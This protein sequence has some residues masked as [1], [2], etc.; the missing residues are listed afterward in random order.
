MFR[1]LSC[2]TTEHDYR[3][4][5]LAVVICA[6]ASLTAFHLFERS[7]RTDGIQCLGW[8]F[9]TG[10]ATG[11]GIWATHFVAMLAF[12]PGLPVSYD[13]VLTGISLVIAV[14]VTTLGFAVG[15]ISSTFTWRALGGAIVGAGIASMHYTGMK[16]FLISGR[17]EWDTSLVVSSVVIGVLF[18]ALSLVASDRLTGKWKVPVC[19]A[20]L[21]I[22]ICGLHFTAMG[23]A[24]IVP[25][26]TVW[27]V[28]AVLD[29]TIMAL[30]VTGTSL[31]VIFAGVTAV[32]IDTESTREA[33]TRAQELV[34][35]TIEG[36][37]VARD[38]VVQNIN[39][40]VSELTGYAADDLL[41]KRIWPDLFKGTAPQVGSGLEN[42]ETSLKTRDGKEVPVEIV[43]RPYN[44][45]RQANEVYAI[46][47]LR[48]RIKAEE[49][50]SYLAHNDVLTGL[51]NR[52]S[53]NRELN[54]VLRNAEPT[55][56]PFAVMCLDLDRFKDVN[57]VMGHD[58]GDSVLE[59]AARR[60]VRAIGDKGFLARVGGDEFIVVQNRHR[61]PEGIEMLATALQEAFRESFEVEFQV[62]QLGISAGIALYPQNGTN[63][64]EL[65]SN[66]DT[67]LYRAKTNGRGRYCF[68]E[69][70]MDERQR[71][72]RKLAQALH[73]ALA[74]DQ[75][76]LN[77]QPQVQ[78]ST[79]QIIGF[80][81][82][83]RWRHPEH[84]IVS[85]SDFIP[86][87]EETGLIV[88]IGEWAL[89]TACA[90]AAMWTH[91]C[92]VAV[93]LSPR[94][95]QQKE[96][97][98]MVL[99]I[100]E[101]TRLD[102]SRLELEITETT[103]FQDHQNALK[104]L[105]K[106]KAL[107]V[108]I[109]MDDFGTGYSSLSTLQS[110]P[111]DKIKIDRSFVD[112]VETAKEAAAI[113]KSVLGLGK[114]LN[115]PVL[116]EGVER[117]GQLEFLAREQCE[118]VQGFY[119]GRPESS[120]HVREILKSGSLLHHCLDRLKASHARENGEEMPAA[121]AKSV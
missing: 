58:A 39:R 64:H 118:A 102:P 85:P 57:D 91:K 33:V 121:L 3:L 15:S 28:P 62:V 1:V 90:E 103:L 20:L 80:E 38:G 71:R 13:P 93:N 107:G 110:F 77:Y 21:T 56:E 94:Q 2:L 99:Q 70:E 45:D 47:D 68:F 4:V 81:A 105:G 50:I 116:A 9:H 35:A 43:Y 78:L 120:E 40:R 14:G 49:R 53:L 67:A 119:F 95:F 111:F 32:L 88:P 61:Q 55:R 101:E 25:D 10:V 46:R 100:L 112:R 29:D 51:P 108:S 117:D 72:R 113:V 82:L 31:L 104:V 5:L 7:K 24:I 22:G 98:G 84:G 89:R 76:E 6:I 65:L 63:M 75:F 23:A 27:V 109:A 73:T 106:L 34:D 87:A 19:A 86:I 11:A 74:A 97:P 30:A 18:S 16:A 96:L 114:S 60:M 54:R 52:T 44:S 12:Q 66:A 17:V 41:G 8:L 37:I 83:L 79:A 115:I 92:K 36:V 69:P 59:E 42:Q 48:E 26:P